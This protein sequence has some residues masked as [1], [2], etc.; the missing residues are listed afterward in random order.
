MGEHVVTS[1]EGY[2][3]SALQSEHRVLQTGK[4][5]RAA[6]QSLLRMKTFYTAE[7]KA[8]NNWNWMKAVSLTNT[9]IVL[10]SPSLR[11]RTKGD[12]QC[13]GYRAISQNITCPQ[14]ETKSS[15][16]PWCTHT[17]T[18]TKSLQAR[19]QPGLHSIRKKHTQKKSS[20]NSKQSCNN[21]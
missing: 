20:K 15:T 9:G 7:I 14:A 2:T 18:H 17:N 5:L 13:F 11:A 12:L 4:Y 6:E 1:M 16:S 21:I 8:W 19:I 3:G 10:S